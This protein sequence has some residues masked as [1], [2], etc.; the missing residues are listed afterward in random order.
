MEGSTSRAEGPYSTVPRDIWSMSAVNYASMAGGEL[1]IL[2]TT[3]FFAV[4][5][6]L[7]V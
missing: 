5:I 4:S 3:A 6:R 7:L 1:A 2:S